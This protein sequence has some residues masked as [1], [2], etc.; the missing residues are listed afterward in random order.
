VAWPEHRR[1]IPAGTIEV[2]RR[3]PKADEWERAVFDPTN[4]AAG[5]EMSG[6]P[7]LAFRPHAYSVSAGRRL[8]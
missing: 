8:S 3:S 1:L 4:L 6:D 7:V 2:L 5:V